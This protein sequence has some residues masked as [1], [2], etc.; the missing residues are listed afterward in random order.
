[1]PAGFSLDGDGLNAVIK[2]ETRTNFLT[3]DKKGLAM[4]A[5][6]QIPES[7]DSDGN[8]VEKPLYHRDYRLDMHRWIARMFANASSLLP[9]FGNDNEDSVDVFIPM[10]KD[11]A[12]KNGDFFT[13]DVATN[14]TEQTIR[15]WFREWKLIADW[16][17]LDDSFEQSDLEQIIRGKLHRY[18]TAEIVDKRKGSTDH[19]IAILPTSWAGW[20]WTLIARD[21]YDGITY[22]PCGNFENCGHEVASRSLKGNKQIH[23]SSRCAKAFERSRLGTAKLGEFELAGDG[24]DQETP[25]TDGQEPAWLFEW[26]PELKQAIQKEQQEGE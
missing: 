14:T 13:N 19:D 9:D 5:W 18:T 21:F 23:C 15:S 11:F 8:T 7:E 4:Y 10:L 25:Q 16:E 12:D 3:G 26:V 2:W 1:M 22:P 6:E 17:I 24:L 20:C